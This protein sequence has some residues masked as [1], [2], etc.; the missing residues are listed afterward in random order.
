MAELSGGALRPHCHAVGD[1]QKRPGSAQ[2]ATETTQ[3]H[4]AKRSRTSA[5]L[6]TA[7]VRKHTLHDTSLALC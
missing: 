1:Q 6:E 5:K 2:A 7:R 3:Q 4:K